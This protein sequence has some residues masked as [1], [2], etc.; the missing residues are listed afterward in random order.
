[1]TGPTESASQIG[2]GAERTATSPVASQLLKPGRSAQATL[3]FARAGNYVSPQCHHVNVLYLKIF[4]P[5]DTTATYAG[6][7]EKVCAET[8]LPTMTITTVAPDS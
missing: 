6:I 2:A 5:G 7:D 4:P 3:Q 8:T 1:V